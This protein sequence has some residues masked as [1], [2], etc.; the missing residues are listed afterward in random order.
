MTRSLLQSVLFAAS[1]LLA[2]ISPDVRAAYPEKPVTLVV[3][4]APGGMTDTVGRMLATE[5]GKKFGQTFVVENKA[6]AAGQVGTEYV[7]RQKNDGYTL[8]ISATGHVIGPAVSANVRYQPVKDFEPIAILA[9]APNLF[10]VNA[11]LPVKNLSEFIAWGKTQGS[12]P[13]GSA[14]FGGS[15]HLGGEL[16][17]QVAGVPLEHVPY[18]G[19]SPAT[20]A[21]V[22]GEIPFA[23]QDSM[24]VAP[25]IK[26]G[27]LRP[28]AVASVNRSGLFPDVKTVSESGFAGFD[29]YTW[30]GLYAPAGTDPKIIAELNA[31]TNRIMNS[32]EMTSRLQQQNS[33]PG[34]VMSPGQVKDFVQ[35]ETEKW[36][37]MVKVTGVKVDN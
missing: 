27:Q 22:S 28:I 33:E 13:Y 2:T 19:A 9:R 4:F 8:L 11:K 10:V 7:A 23:V 30:L 36:K 32:P 20:L 1:G 25:Y 21:L 5:L 3:S 17:R 31:A 26:S 18:K 15:T 16:F 14:G 12:V 35:A 24:S 37:E 6:G 34:G 29:V